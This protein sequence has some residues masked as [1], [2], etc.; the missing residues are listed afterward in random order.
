MKPVELLSL[1]IALIAFSLLLLHYATHRSHIQEYHSNEAASNNNGGV[2]NDGPNGLDIA[3][4]M[5]IVKLQNETIYTLESHLN[6]QKQRESLQ[7]MVSSSSTSLATAISAR[8][9][10]ERTVNELTQTINQLTNEVSHLKRQSVTQVP[11]TAS[12]CNTSSSAAGKAGGARGSMS[13]SE[14]ETTCQSLISSTVAKAKA[15]TQHSIDLASSSSGDSSGRFSGRT[16]LLPLTSLQADCERRFGIELI[17]QWKAS[18][19]VWCDAPTSQLVCYPYHQHHKKLDGRGTDVFCEAT[20]FIID[21]SKIHGQV[22]MQKKPSKGTEYLQFGAGSLQSS[23]QKTAFYSSK[24]NRFMPHHALQMRSFEDS[25]SDLDISGSGSGVPNG[26]DA[27]VD[28]PTYLLARDEDCENSFHSTADFMNMFLVYSTL[29]LSFKDTQVMLFDKYPD[30]PYH[31][32]IQKAFSPSHPVLRHTHYTVSKGQKRVLF[33][34]LV[35]HLESPAGLIFPKVSRPDP[36]RCYDTSLFNAYRR[37]V[38]QSFDLLD[39][40]PPTIPSVVLSLRHRTPQKNVGRVMSNEQDVITVLQKGNMMDLHIIDGAKMSY[41][42]QL[43]LIRNSNVLIGIHG[44]G[45]MFIMFAAEEAVLVEI[46]PSYRQDRHFR[47]AARMTGKI[48]MPMRSSTRESCHGSSDSITVPIDEFQRTVDGALRIA[49]NF[50]D[51]L[52]ECGLTCPPGILALDSRLNSHYKS[53]ESRG[54]PMNTRF[55]CG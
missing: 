44:A 7:K 12:I 4:L 33:R 37:H 18:K 51:G 5:H 24:G 46:H 19:Q 29:G 40:P 10:S 55:P 35:F 42:E 32:L 52:S 50:D 49:R 20:N 14:L 17:E 3:S 47:H 26:V 45:L 1:F 23:C 16:D 6:F 28:T 36:L 43:K 13:S 48:Y 15:N 21:F 25:R 54:R 9:E 38:L 34:R 11:S 2:S 27:V 39:I 30:G 53:G 31:E 22:S 8:E 41:G